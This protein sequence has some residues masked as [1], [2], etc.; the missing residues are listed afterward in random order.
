MRMADPDP[1][2]AANAVKGGAYR[3]LKPMTVEQ[4][5]NTPGLAAV[6]VETDVKQLIAT[7]EKCIAAD[8]HIH[9]DKPAGESLPAFKRLCTEADRRKRTIQMGYMLR[10]NPAFELLF[11]ATRKGWLGDIFELDG[12]MGKRA[13]VGLRKELSQYAGGGMFELACHLIDAAVTVLG[14]PQKVTAFTR[15]TQAPRDTFADNQLAVLSYPKATATIRCN[16]NDPF[17]GPR[18]R[19]E[20]SGSA[21]TFAVRPLESG[22]VD[23][24]LTEAREPYR[25]GT[26]HVSLKRKGGRYD[27]EF[28]DLARVMRGEKA[29]AWDRAH[30]LAVHETVLRAAD[31]PV[32]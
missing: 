6:A 15:R 16:H 19:F 7:A 20:V 31:M 4:L 32:D 3:D 17:G 30:D 8:L 5:L 14:P 29:L 25:K 11:E 27:A 26:Q 1:G 12:M 2:R 13:S 9:L 24:M 28:V 18:R 22:E 10:Y 21:G 23:L